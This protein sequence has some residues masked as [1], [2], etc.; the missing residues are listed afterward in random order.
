MLIVLTV[1]YFPFPIS[2]SLTKWQSCACLIYM[3]DFA[4]DG[5]VLGECVSSLK[6]EYMN[7]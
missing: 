5:W 6:H 7:T 4:P 1:R 3:G 2:L